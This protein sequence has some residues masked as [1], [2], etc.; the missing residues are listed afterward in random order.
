MTPKVFPSCSLESYPKNF[1]AVDVPQS[2]DD[3]TGSHDHADLVASS[4]LEESA[5][6]CGNL[7]SFRIVRS[8][9]LGR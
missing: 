4:R 1:C 5:M 6:I 7:Y 8:L 9:V 3:S 2:I